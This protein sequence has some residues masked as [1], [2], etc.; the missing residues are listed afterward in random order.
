[1]PAKY[2]RQ[3]KFIGDVRRPVIYAVVDSDN[4]N[5]IATG[6][7]LFF[8]NSGAASFADVTDQ[9]TKLQNQQYVRDLFL[10]IAQSAVAAN[11]SG[12]VLVARSGVFEVPCA[13]AT[14]AVGNYVGARGTTAGVADGGNDG[15]SSTTVEK[16]TDQSAAIGRVVRAGTTVTTVQIE[17]FPI[18]TAPML[19]NSSRFDTISELTA[20]VGVTIDS[21]L[22]KDGGVLCPNPSTGIGYST[23]AGGT[24][25]QGT[26]RTTAVTL[27]KVSGA[28]TLFTAAGSATA[29][30]FTVNNSV[31]AA[32]DT[33][34]L[35]VKSGT[36]K[37]LV[38]VT[39][40]GA[41]SFEIT[42]WTTGGTASDAP[43]INFN[44]LKGVAA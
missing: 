15:V 28:I 26:N 34:S 39:A 13:S 33:I 11:A 2:I 17:I 25:T 27:N 4:S 20:N 14:Y 9:G 16:V 5:G 21:T 30:S 44:V 24:V 23:G 12:N 22:V 3:S 18:N 6:D 19:D 10:G 35:S 43:V 29:A 42:F 32:T 38:M 31:V 7:F 1:M 36:N 37:Y 40:V 41:G 8:S